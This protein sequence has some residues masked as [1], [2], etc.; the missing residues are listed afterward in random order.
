M[1]GD[2]SPLTRPVIFVLVA[3]LCIIA[4]IGIGLA[5]YVVFMPYHLDGYRVGLVMTTLFCGAAALASV[6][7]LFRYV[8]NYLQNAREP[9][10]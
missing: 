1:P 10:L 7:Y 4:G 8:V 6:P 5:I 2:G 9:D 3:V